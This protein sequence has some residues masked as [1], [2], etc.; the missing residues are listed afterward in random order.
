MGGRIP[1]LEFQSGTVLTEGAIVK[2]LLDT[3][4]WGGTRTELAAA[5]HDVVWTGDWPQ[6]P[7]DEEILTRAHTEG[8][9]L[10]TL[11]KD[12]GELAIVRGTPHCGILRLVNIAARQ[13]AA[14]CLQVIEQYGAELYAGT[15]A[16][17]GSG[18]LR[19]RPPDEAS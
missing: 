2:I 7:G 12:F 4:V 15:I 13:Q 16:T 10:V 11:D 19:L 17:A 9:I 5:G 14:V 6:D 8:R 1:V 18:R 3:C